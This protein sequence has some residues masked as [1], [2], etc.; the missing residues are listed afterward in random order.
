MNPHKKVEEWRNNF[1][2]K[3]KKK[4][5]KLWKIKTIEMVLEENRKYFKQFCCVIKLEH[6]KNI[7]EKML[8][9]Y[10]KMLY[11]QKIGHRIL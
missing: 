7:D 4:R 3:A 10:T 2:V 9:I 6:E 1:S 8:Y 5:K 11:S